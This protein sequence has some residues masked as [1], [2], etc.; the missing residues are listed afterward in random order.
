MMADQEQSDIYH[1]KIGHIEAKGNKKIEIFA[2][3]LHEILHSQEE[4]KPKVA[5]HVSVKGSEVFEKQLKTVF[6]PSSRK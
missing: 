2:E 1:Q 4:I 3:E 6:E 5:S